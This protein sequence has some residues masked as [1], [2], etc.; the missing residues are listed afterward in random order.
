MSRRAT[1]AAAACLLV[2]LVLSA[3]SAVDRGAARPVWASSR[4]AVLPAAAQGVVA[5]T[6]GHADRR[7]FARRTSRGLA[8]HAGGG[9]AASFTARGVAVRAGGTTWR[10]GLRAIGRGPPLTPVGSSAPAARANRVSYARKGLVEWYANG[11]LGLEQGFTVRSRPA[12]TAPLTLALGKLPSGLHA[13]LSRDR[14]S[15]SLARGHFAV[16]RYRD[17]A[18]HDARGRALPARIVVSNRRL[19]LRVDDR[20][21]S[22]PIRVD[23]FVEAATL[24]AS[25]YSAG[26]W[27]GF[28]VAISGDTIAVGAQRA[29]GGAGAVYVFV[30]P[31][32]GWGT[33]TETAE[34]TASDGNVNDELGSSVAISGDT[35][36]AGAPVYNS[37]EGKVYVFLEPGGG[38]GSVP[39]QHETAILTESV[40]QGPAPMLG[41]AVAVSGDGATVVAGAS[42]AMIGGSQAQG[43]VYVFT[44]PGGGW[45]S[46][47]ETAL[48]TASDGAAQ[49]D[50]GGGAVNGGVGISSDGETIVAGAGGA[51]IGANNFQGAVY[52][53]AKP[54][55]GWSSSVHESAKLTASD[56]AATDNLGR[57]GVAIDGDTVVGGAPGKAAYVFVKPGGGWS[58]SVHESAKLTSSDAS[59]SDLGWSV[60]VSGST[61]VVGGPQYGSGLGAAYVYL[62]PAGG[63]SGT[64]DEDQKLVWDGPL[65]SQAFFGSSLAMDAGTL[66]AGAYSATLVNDVDHAQQGAVNVYAGTA[67]TKRPT[68]TAVSCVPASVTVGSAT[69]CGATV[70][71]TGSGST[72][73]PTGTVS[74]SSSS[75]G[76]FNHETCT[77]AR[78]NS[79][80]AGCVVGYT[81]SAVDSG[82]H[83]ISAAYA[84]DGTH[85]GSGGHGALSVH[86]PPPAPPRN[87]TLPSIAPDQSCQFYK[88]HFFC[89]TIPHQYVCNAGAWSGNDTSIP[90]QFEW[91]ELY[92]RSDTDPTTF[93]RDEASGQTYYAVQHVT[94]YVPTG[95]FRCVVTATGPGG[96]TAAASPTAPLQTVSSLPFGIKPPAPVNIIVTG[97]EVTQAV[98]SSG[99]AG[100]LGVLPSRDQSNSNAPGQATYQ[101]VTLAQ[102]KFTVVR[103]FAHTFGGTTVSGATAQ[104]EV[105]DSNGSRIALLGP[106]SSPPAVTPMI[107]SFCVRDPERANPGSSFN[108]LVPWQDTNQSLLTFRATVTPPTGPFLPSQCGGCRGNVFTLQSVPFVPVATIRI[109]PIPLTLTIGGNCGTNNAS[110]CTSVTP[111]QVFNDA[112]TLMP[113]HFEI[114]PYESPLQVDGT[115]DAC[116]AAG[117]VSNRG[118]ADGYGPNDYEIGVFF[119]GMGLVK[120]GCTLGYKLF[121]NGAASAVLDSGRSISSVTHEIGHGL[122][123]KHAGVEC[124][125]GQDNDSDDTN[126]SGTPWSPDVWGY[127]DSA[128]F[129]RR[130]WDIYKTGSLPGTYMQDFNHDGTPAGG[131]KYYD[132]MSYCPGGDG[133]PDGKGNGADNTNHW[134]SLVNWNY[135]IGY[136]T[137]QQARRLRVVHGASMRM[138][139][140][141]HPDGS[142]SILS[143]SPGQSSPGGPTAGSLYRIDVRDAGGHVLDAVV[144]TTDRVHVD[145]GLQPPDLM[146]DATLPLTADT[147]AV[148]VTYNG[149]EVA[150][151]SRSAHAPVV[152]FLAPRRRTKLRGRTTFVRWSAHDADGGSLTSTVEY[153]A[154]GGSHWKVVADGLKGGTAR[155]PSRFLSASRNARLR[156]LVSDGFNLTTETSGRLSA[157]GAPPTVQ[158]LNAPRRGHVL[159]TTTLLLQ[160]SAFDDADRPLTGHRLKWYLGKRLIGTGEQVTLTNVQP[161]SAAIRLVATDAHG[162]SAKATLPLR[163]VAGKPRY[164]LFDAPL[165]VSPRA[166]TVRI[167]VASST[168]ATFTI[169]G[170]HYAVSFRQRTV[171]VRV[172]RGRSPIGL[173]CSLRSPGGVI[174]GTYVAVRA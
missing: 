18:A 120:N 168:A 123:L 55:G 83:V 14:R 26:A 93:W 125:G 31:G 106:D 99:C 53:F 54:A 97:I 16:L 146:L 40:E 124:G 119:A 157:A 96:S 154:D 45:S 173:R 19:A 113:Y 24:S 1:G 37:Q 118:A 131:T 75:H 143:V 166:R 32:G 147:A 60:A 68:S 10:L 44:K 6:L 49:Q 69:T 92:Q 95:T 117:T 61:L 84:G 4:P 65:F 138:L 9:V 159:A 3:N 22:Y 94:P 28:S 160:G 163:V 130:S 110:G 150:R 17:L 126:Q 36:V 2:A 170:K 128:G 109:H 107:C 46:E 73:A 79:A 167:K 86:L 8:L 137:P 76:S 78:L 15:M 144:P 63:W 112:E 42:N 82:T 122:G 141:V 74:F 56:G 139:A 29:N 34:L 7:F 25:D 43:A 164:L 85:T 59:S 38:W 77:L 20:G 98:Q 102:G 121:D 174:R 11:P 41:N 57:Y 21:A 153:S 101:G 132:F 90:Y 62:E 23:P 71:D 87:T 88:G 142:T 100:C 158:I 136:P 155:V 91:Q 52:V 12:G 169:A 149:H 133:Q 35:V 39:N 172:R 89:T 111:Q 156:V 129:D 104:L 151:R 148:T 64:H 48:L 105:L 27:F 5:R 162:R 50:L 66:V 114:L 165:L 140:I 81:P 70:T 51:K 108:F 103:V 33:G 58:G 152:K 72:V 134:I 67:S 47:H 115:Q 135:L 13:R 30:E 145:H 161:G 116:A 171:T 127:L 80:S